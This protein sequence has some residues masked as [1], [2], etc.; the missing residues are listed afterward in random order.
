METIPTYLDSDFKELVLQV[1]NITRNRSYC[2][3][4]EGDFV[5]I[6]HAK[7]RGGFNPYSLRYFILGLSFDQLPLYINKFG[8]KID[9]DGKISDQIVKWRLQIGK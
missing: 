2:T 5:T 1:W 6:K 8:K 3:F 9:K 7:E 4:L